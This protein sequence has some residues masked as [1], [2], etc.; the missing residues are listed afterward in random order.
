MNN[1]AAGSEPY[2]ALVREA[3]E[4]AAGNGIFLMT[5]KQEKNPMTIGWC[6]WGVIWGMPVCTVLVRQTRYSHGLLERDGVFT[7]CA[8]E[9]GTMKKD[10]AF[11]G[12]RSGR[13]MDKKAQL[14]LATVPARA[15][16]V[17]ALAGC[18]LHFECEVVFKL[19]MGGHMDTLAPEIRRRF[20][21]PAAQEGEDGN[22]H[23]VYFGK[24]VAAYRAQQ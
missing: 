23:T 3:A 18:A 17:D 5:G 8:P 21:D 7:V 1:A 6:Q 4:Q 19:E 22:P 9:K 16:G 20:Y 13:D 10:L 12:S 14:K 24:I 15:G 2:E 11:C